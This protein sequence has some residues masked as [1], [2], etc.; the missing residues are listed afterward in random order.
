[1]GA[2]GTLEGTYLGMVEHNVDTI[3]AAL[4]G[5]PGNRQISPSEP[6]KR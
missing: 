5:T 6:G 3:V 1:M 2:P 4:G